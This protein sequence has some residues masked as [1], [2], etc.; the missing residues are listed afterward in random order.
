MTS[1]SH[2]AHD[3]GLAPLPFCLAPTDTERAALPDLR[4]PR[5]GE[6]V[7]LHEAHVYWLA[8]RLPSRRHTRRSVVLWAAPIK[9]GA[10]CSGAAWDDEHLI[11]ADP[12]D[13]CPNHDERKVLR[14]IVE[15]LLG[16]ANTTGTGTLSPRTDTTPA[17]AHLGIDL[18]VS[19]W[20]EAALDLAANNLEQAVEPAGHLV[21]STYAVAAER[22]ITDPD[23][24]QQTIDAC[25]AAIGLVLLTDYSSAGLIDR[26]KVTDPD[27]TAR[28]VRAALGSHPR[29][30]RPDL[31]RHAAIKIAIYRFAD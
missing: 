24:I 16:R 12:G 19:E 29:E 30:L 25:Y 22:R 23:L 17:T 9:P 1:A 26:E 18:R 15:V 11:V 31:A 2:R 21:R 14:V 7:V 4:L 5:A 13:P 6:H 28:A 27:A 20:A 3:E 8:A 10:T